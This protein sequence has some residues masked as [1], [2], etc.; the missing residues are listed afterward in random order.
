MQCFPEGECGVVRFE[1]LSSSCNRGCDWE[2]LAAKRI[3]E[4]EEILNAG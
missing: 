3:V 2:S 1:V 4:R